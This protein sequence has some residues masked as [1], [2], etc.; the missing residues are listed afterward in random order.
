M[1][2]NDRNPMDYRLEE[3]INRYSAQTS[4]PLDENQDSS[5]KIVCNE[6]IA[7]IANEVT[8]MPNDKDP[9]LWRVRVHVSL[10]LFLLHFGH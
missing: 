9:P 3:V 4:W 1:T 10:S 8:Q 6:D 2:G 7:S 5:P